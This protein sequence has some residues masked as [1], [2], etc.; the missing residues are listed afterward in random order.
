MSKSVITIKIDTETKKAARALADDAGITIS[1]L[2][3]S[4]LKQ[5]V[6]TRHINLRI[7]QS[8]SPKTEA[9]LDEAEADIAIGGVVG[10]FNS[11]REAVK[12]LK[13]EA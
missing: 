3:N 8:M 7:P 6:A 9:L 10:P 13:K 11:A 2:V 4:Y 5:V 1:S 12:A